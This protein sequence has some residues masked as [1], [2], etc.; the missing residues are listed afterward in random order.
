M[1]VNS[2]EDLLIHELQDLYSAEKQLTKVLPRMAKVTTNPALAELFRRHLEETQTHVTRLE[3]I[4]AELGAHTCSTPC[5][6]MEGLI[7]EADHLLGDVEDDSVRDAAIIGAAQRVEHYEIAG[8]GT[9]RTYAQLLGNLQVAEML[10]RT[11]DEEHATDVKLTTLAV[12]RIN[13]AAERTDAFV[14][15]EIH[16]D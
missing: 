15:R 3:D 13:D 4:L 11:L 7:A 1:K 9:A 5:K 16:A 12:G 6:A 8:Y 2:M 14:G 10:Q